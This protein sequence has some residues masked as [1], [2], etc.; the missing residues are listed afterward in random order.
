MTGHVVAD[1]DAC[2]SSC[3]FDLVPTVEQAVVRA[4]RR[5]ARKLFGCML[6]EC[7]LM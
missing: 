4:C 5:N 6:L 1:A 2:A 7:S 3:W